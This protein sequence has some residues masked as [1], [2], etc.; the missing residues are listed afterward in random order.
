[1]PLAGC[2]ACHKNL[3]FLDGFEQPFSGFFSALSRSGAPMTC[4]DF[5][6]F[7]DLK[8][9]VPE[10]K[11][12][13]FPYQNREIFD[14]YVLQETNL[15]GITA[16]GPPASSQSAGN[17]VIS[18]EMINALIAKDPPGIWIPPEG[19]ICL[20]LGYQYVDPA[21][22]AMV[23]EAPNVEVVK[24]LYPGECHL[25]AKE[26]KRYTKPKEFTDWPC[27]E[28]NVIVTQ[29]GDS[30][31]V[32]SSESLLQAIDRAARPDARI[33]LLLAV[34][35]GGRGPGPALASRA[36][37]LR[38]RFPRLAVALA[39]RAAYWLRDL[40]LPTDESRKALRLVDPSGQLVWRHDGGADAATIAEALREHLVPAPPP[41][42]A[43]LQARVQPGNPPP[44]FALEIAPGDRIALRDLL[45]GRLAILFVAED[46][47][48]EAVLRRLSAPIVAADK[49]R[50]LAIII[51]DGAP[52]DAADAP[53]DLSFDWI[54]VP[55][56]EREIARAY[57]V[58]VRPTAVLVDWDGRVSSVQLMATAIANS[59]R[60]SAARHVQ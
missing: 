47:A 3:D 49:P 42:G 13:E 1:M 4:L 55:D 46:A 21:T 2:V 43:F 36:R 51:Q 24:K 32:R 41:R 9:Y 38:Q 17:A 11:E 19:Q 20:F 34:N 23:T 52:G 7:E 33:M 59:R 8:D 5:W 16:I 6:R 50:M 45:G 30:E 57:G 18:S 22:G 12:L 35:I 54:A 26:I 60:A 40:D 58:T 14:R 25:P 39:D 15:P 44:D 31:F 27:P 10:A 28:M 37:E 56:P 53:R 48:L 29:P